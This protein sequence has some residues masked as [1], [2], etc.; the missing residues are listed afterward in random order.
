MEALDERAV[1][2]V[3]ETAGEEDPVADVDLEIDQARGFAPEDDPERADHAK[4]EGGQAME[5]EALAHQHRAEESG[6]ARHDCEQSAF[7]EA[8]GVAQRLEHAPEEEGQGRAEREIAGARAGRRQRQPFAPGHDGR[9][10]E[11]G[12]DEA[13]AHHHRRVEAVGDALAQGKGRG[14]DDDYQEG[15]RVRVRLAR[16]RGPAW[17]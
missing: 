15:E 14:N 2:G 16:A 13:D 12:E 5:A 8:A 4:D 7:V 17:L 9:H 6:E 3:T 11:R 1:D 10:E